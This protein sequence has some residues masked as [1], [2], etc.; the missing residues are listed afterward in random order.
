MKQIQD[1][2][3]V[4]KLVEDYHIRTFFDTPHLVFC[5]LSWNKGEVICSPLNAP[6]YLLFLVQG[7]IRMYDLHPDGT[8]S[9]VAVVSGFALVGDVEYVTNAKPRYYLEA[10]EDC[11]CV[12]L[13]FAPYREAL[14]Q[15]VTFLHCMLEVMADKFT[16]ST[17]Q[18][19]SAGDLEERLLTYLREEAPEHKMEGVEPALCQLRCSRR[20]LQR[21]LSKLCQEGTLLRL[22]KG[23]YQ[24]NTEE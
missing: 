24:L 16:E 11:V 6:E 13:P 8:T 1:Q 5:A 23:R 17:E 10:A 15:D 3:M 21:V 20:Q 14:E 2:T 4:E 22:G 18:S 9:P 7:S 19:F 12:A